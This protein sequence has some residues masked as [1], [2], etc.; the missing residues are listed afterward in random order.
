MSSAVFMGERSSPWLCSPFMLK[1]G[2]IPALTSVSVCSAA[3]QSHMGLDSELNS[4]SK[5]AI[6]TQRHV[7]MTIIAISL[8]PTGTY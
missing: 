5:Q 8:E 6:A 1:S 2:I 7:L 3:S 4:D